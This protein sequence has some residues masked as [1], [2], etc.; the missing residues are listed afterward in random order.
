M[1]DTDRMTETF[2]TLVRIDSPSFE[3]REIAEHL[4]TELR[5]L[6]GDVIMDDSG[7]AVGGN[8]GNIFSRFAGA[9]RGPAVLLSAH[10]DTVS[11]GRGVRPVRDGQRIRSDGTTILGADDKSGIAIILEVL[12][13]FRERKLPHPPIEVV[14]TVCEEPGLMGAKSLHLARLSAQDGLVLDSG[15]ASSLFI[16]GPAA[17]R[18]EVTVRGRAAH[19]GVCPERGM[20]A[21]QVAADAIARMRLGRLDHETTANIGLIEGG[22]AVNIVP[23]R[24]T[25]RGE[26]RS[27]DEE[28]LAAQSAHMV[29]CFHDAA[30]ARS[31]RAGQELVQAEIE[32]TI[33]RDYNRMR[34]GEGAPVVQWVLE[35]ARQAKAMIRCES[36]GGGCD[37]NVFNSHGMRIANLGT[38]MR[39]IHTTGEYLLLEEFFQTGRVVFS[40]LQ[41][42]VSR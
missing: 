4:L 6:G 18:L 35:A 7:A 27:H 36:T 42:A 31:I 9:G 2:L 25:V 26:A 29:R 32:S 33:T 16:R 10:M 11:P 30:A 3:E 20:S 41:Q 12:R 5:T 38:G 22:T 34:L 13:A 19:A 14:F 8:A 24:V 23:D 15:P 28:K 17:D 40:M 37:A 39:E 21:I 1:I